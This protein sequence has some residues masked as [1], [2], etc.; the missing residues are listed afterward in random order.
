MPLQGHRARKIKPRPGDFQEVKGDVQEAPGVE[1]EV[2]VVDEPAWQPAW[3][4][5]S[6]LKQE[7]SADTKLA[8]TKL[9]TEAD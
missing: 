6:G 3:Q 2:Q 4:P 7:K 9:E 1:V 5:A 8:D